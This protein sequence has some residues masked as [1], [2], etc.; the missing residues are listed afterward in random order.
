[1]SHGA[2]PAQNDETKNKGVIINPLLIFIATFDVN[3]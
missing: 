3:V 1:M 2:W